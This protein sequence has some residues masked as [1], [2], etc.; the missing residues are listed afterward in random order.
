MGG[1][2]IEMID[3]LRVIWKRKLLIIIVTMV[4]VVV[5][6]V[7]VSRVPEMYRA[8]ILLRMG[9]RMA[10]DPSGSFTL[11]TFDSPATIVSILQS[12]SY[13]P[14]GL[15]IVPTLDAVPVAGTDL[16]K[17]TLT[18]VEREVLERINVAVK[19]FCDDHSQ[20][21]K[22]SLQPYY[23][24]V[25]QKR[26]SL[27]DLSERVSRLEIKLN[28]FESDEIVNVSAV[29]S[30]EKD[31]WESKSRLGRLQIELMFSDVFIANEK[32][33]LTSI[34]G[35]MKISNIPSNKERG[36]MKAGTLS[37]V[38]SILLAFLVTYIEKAKK[39]ER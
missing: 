25:D 1:D 14:E 18:G 11:I 30:I 29:V 34:I 7:N 27:R 16:I 23:V 17:I 4:G 19:K 24:A 36:I 15:S 5:G 32:E 9:K 20:K 39:N 37:L 8:N 12:K 2:N 28:E 6:I 22:E 13:F 31:L 26:R 3:Y 38:L 35:S 10:I 21:T 33:Y